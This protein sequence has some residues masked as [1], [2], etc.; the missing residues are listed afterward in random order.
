MIVISMDF[1]QAWK[2]GDIYSSKNVST[3]KN[4]G[5]I[6]EEWQVRVHWLLRDVIPCY[7]LLL[8]MVNRRLLK[9]VY[10]PCRKKQFANIL[11]YAIDTP[12]QMQW[13]S[14]VVLLPT[15]IFT[16]H[17]QSDPKSRGKNRLDEIWSFMAI[18]PCDCTQIL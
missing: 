5:K 7:M 9:V 15:S 2:R 1:Q 17:K 10:C 13:Q 4:F 16:K 3:Q 8:S 14:S 6:Y 12:Y 11:M 18:F